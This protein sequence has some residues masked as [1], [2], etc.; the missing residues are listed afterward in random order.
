M[1]KELPIANHSPVLQKTA[2]LCQTILEQ[3]AYLRM[4]DDIMAF[5]QNEEARAQYEDLCTLQENLHRKQDE[6]AVI[7]DE[8]MEAFEQAE[9]LFLASPQAVPFIEAQ[10][11]MHEIESKIMEYVRRTFEL[12][13][14]PQESDFEGGGCGEGCGCH[15]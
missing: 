2:E 3:P 5:L 1:K 4:R 9:A 10:Q 13:R 6:G 11:S 12:G 15:G 8:E 14:V 7:S